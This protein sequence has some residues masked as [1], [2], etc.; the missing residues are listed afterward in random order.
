[1]D[2]YLKLRT[3]YPLVYD[4]ASHSS[5]T[6]TKKPDPSN[7]TQIRRDKRYGV[8]YGDD[9]SQRDDK[10]EP[11][12]SIVH[13]NMVTWYQGED[14]QMDRC[15][16]LEAPAKQKELEDAVEFEQSEVGQTLKALGSLFCDSTDF[17]LFEIVWE[18]L[19][20]TSLIEK[21]SCFAAAETRSLIG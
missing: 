14:E 21:P 5:Y 20:E 8:L 15:Y 11:D 10:S 3:K 4:I 7:Q 18:S 1:M 2:R 13:T 19:L 16:S 6:D 12:T 9:F 17:D